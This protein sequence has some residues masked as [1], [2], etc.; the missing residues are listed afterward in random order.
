MF[1]PHSAAITANKLNSL[2]ASDMVNVEDV[3]RTF[4][5][6]LRDS[7]YSSTHPGLR[8]LLAFAL[9]FFSARYKGEGDIAVEELLALCA[10]LAQGHTKL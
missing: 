5:Q 1:N 9:G 10:N 8:E 4:M 6:M 2:L 3:K 7:G